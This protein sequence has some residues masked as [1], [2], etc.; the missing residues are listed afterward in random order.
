[1]CFLDVLGAAYGFPDVPAV[2]ARA[3]LVSGKDNEVDR[4]IQDAYINAIRRAKDF[5]YI[6]NQYFLGSSFGWK[7]EQ[8]TGA[9]HLIPAELTR[10]ITSKIEGGERFTVYI[11]MPMWPEGIPDSGSV[12]AILRWTMNT[13]EMMY[14]E[15]ATALRANGVQDAT[16]QDYLTFFCLAN[17]ETKLQS[18]YVP[19]QH[20]EEGS[21][22][23]KAQDARRFMI[24]VHAKMMIGELLAC[25]PSAFW[26]SLY[27]VA[28]QMKENL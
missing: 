18:D 15:I 13:M 11:V 17:R 12:Q 24:Y 21:L 16:P 2:A 23:M 8:D 22:Y 4:S 7:Q 27:L 26:L 9:D 20:P 5:I 28:V 25:F 3:G 19:P 6:E 14:T 10:K 1:M